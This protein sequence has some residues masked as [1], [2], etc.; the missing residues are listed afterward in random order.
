MVLANEVS[1]TPGK[2]PNSAPASSVFN[3]EMGRASAVTTM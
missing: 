1:I 2:R 3:N